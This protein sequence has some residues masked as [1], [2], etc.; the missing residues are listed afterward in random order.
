MTARILIADDHVAVRE[1]VKQILRPHREFQVE[2]E[3]ATL[4]E[5]LAALSSRTFDLLI[6]DLSLGDGNASELFALI[7]TPAPSL[8]IVVY[9]MYPEDELAARLFAS[10]IDAYITKDSSPEI[11]IAA[12]RS[13]A[14]GRKYVTPRIG[15]LLAREGARNRP[16]HD[17]L[18]EREMQVLLMTAEGKSL[19]EIGVAL[20]VSLK[21]V[22]TYRA[23][24]LVKLGLSTSADLIR[25]AIQHR[26]H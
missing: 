15:E 11:L 23:R 1:G 4:A 20:G 12:L 14:S 17:L 24:T 26:L 2:A 16:R 9:T 13:V 21:T 7:R 25:Y 3:V 22:S 6:L 8:P 10:G 5:L 18:S 19:K